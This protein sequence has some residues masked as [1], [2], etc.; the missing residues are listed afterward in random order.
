M[1][2]TS[3]DIPFV[4]GSDTSKEAAESMAAI[5]GHDEAIVFAALER[6]GSRGR[7]DDELEVELGLSHQSASARRRGLVLKNRAHCSGLKRLTRSRRKAFVWLAGP[8]PSPMIANRS[9]A[10]RDPSTGRVEPVQGR[11][12][13]FCQKHFLN[14]NSES[15]LDLE[16]EFARVARD[17]RDK[18]L[19]EAAEECMVVAHSSHEHANVALKCVRA[20]KAL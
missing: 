3:N 6:A 5:H 9:P 1:G 16:A 18:A 7:T 15:M 4:S 17:A 11:A 10:V 20:I 19:A 2:Y 8:S 14:M 13:A 12:G